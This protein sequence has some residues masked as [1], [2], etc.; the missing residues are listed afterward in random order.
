ML[1]QESFSLSTTGLIPGFICTGKNQHLS[2]FF[3]NGR[4]KNWVLLKTS[5][6]TLRDSKFVQKFLNVDF[7]PVQTKP[8][9][10]PLD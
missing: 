3:E 8:R 1:K 2:S 6:K 4:D 5:I 7:Y 9:T 10:T